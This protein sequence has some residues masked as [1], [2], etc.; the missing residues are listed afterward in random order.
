M[1]VFYLAVWLAAIYITAVASQSLPKPSSA[2]FPSRIWQSSPATNWN[3]SFLIGNGRLGAVVGGSVASEVL[4]VNE[5]SLWSGGP[6]ERVNPDASTQMPTMQT[7]VR[8]GDIGDAA[9]LASYAYQGT[10]V[11]AQHY[12]PLGDLTLTMGDPS[13]KTSYYERWLDL[14]DG[15]TGV[16]YTVGNTTY[17]RE[18][19]GSQPA[20]VIAMRIVS[21][22]PGAVSFTLHLDRGEGLN[23]WEDYS[24][25]YGSDTIIMGGASGGLS[26]VGFVAGAKIVAP[27][28]TVSTL[29]DYVFCKNATEAWVYFS[30]W[31]TYRKQDPKEAVLA[32]LAAAGEQSYA[33][34][35]AAHVVDYQTYFNRTSL[36]LGTSTAAQKNQTTLQRMTNLANGSFDPEIASLY[37]QFGRYMLISTSRAGTLPPNLQGIWNSDLDPEWG[38]KYTI[39]INLEMN[40]WPLLVTNLAELGS[41]LYDFLINMMLPNG[42]NVAQRM[43]NAS[44]AVAH[45]NSDAWGDCAPQ[46]NYFDSTFW[47]GGLAWL[48]THV[49][50]DYLYTGNTTL[51]RSSWPLMRSVLQFYLTFMTDGP[52]GWKVTNPSLSPENNYYLPNSTIQ[53]AITMGPTVDNSLVWELIG[54]A[55]ESM[56]ILG[57]ED[58]QFAEQLTT[59]RAQ[60]PPIR[61]NYFGGVQEWIY[62]YKEV[63]CN[64]RA[65]SML[66]P[67]Y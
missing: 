23:R 28:G 16:Y 29:G 31:T 33:D 13:T 47:P 12:D 35:R 42:T 59:L 58:E 49:M 56:N 37:F 8:N 20:G 63:G 65:E 52:N 11:S 53:E 36:N 67:T 26:P 24:Q 66:G 48:T 7:E 9:T 2:S 64:A 46:D 38:S 44:G 27:G 30:S 15:T 21:N 54:Y 45:H 3:D 19:L 39:N 61:V 34:I 41:P 40:Y 25:K 32:D 1:P 62:D 51:L 57:E 18:L 55:L 43:Y 22:S 4:H 50:Q 6:L 60:L 17:Q 5:D 10:P 14:A